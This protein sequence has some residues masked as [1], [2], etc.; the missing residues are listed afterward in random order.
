MRGVVVLTVLSLTMTMS[1]RLG[2][3]RAQTPV[4]VAGLTW[5]PCP[6]AMAGPATPQ[7]AS[8][9]GLECATLHVPLDHADPDG[10]QI[11]IGLNRLPARDPAQRIG[12][13]IFNP[14][15]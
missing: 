11:T 4:P 13:L 1:G 8:A 9:S 5:K 2:G 12:S 10:E 6:P 7:A 15:G 14:G 3:A